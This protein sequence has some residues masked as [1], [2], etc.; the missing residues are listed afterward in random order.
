[1]KA[2]KFTLSNISNPFLSNEVSADLS[3]DSNDKSLILQIKGGTYSCLLAGDIST[4]VE[5]TLVQNKTDLK[6]SILLSP[7]HGSQTSNSEEFIAAVN[8]KQIIVSAGRFKPLLFPSPELRSICQDN[9]IQLLIT[10]ET[11]AITFREESETLKRI[12]FNQDT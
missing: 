12:S 3:T 10:S 9:H 11:G 6:S 8:P 1:M 4:R 7:H 5:H 2:E